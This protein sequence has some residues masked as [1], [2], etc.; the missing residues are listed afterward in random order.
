MMQLFHLIFTSK[1]AVEVTDELLRDL[2]DK[3]VHRNQSRGITGVL[4]YSN[5]RFLQL[6]E[7][8]AED[9]AGTF[10]RISL[11]V[12][13]TDVNCVFF[14]LTDKRMFLESSMGVATIDNGEI[15][16]TVE[17]LFQNLSASDHHDKDRYQ[18]TAQSFLA[19]K[20]QVNPETVFSP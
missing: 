19:F 15:H 10:A 2:Q 8:D 11:D 5:H 7:G 17:E 4:L 14:G 12:R 6:L 9:I 16:P 13:H 1:S 3:A 20:E 18:R